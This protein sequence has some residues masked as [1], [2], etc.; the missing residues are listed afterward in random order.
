MY[1]DLAEGK[2]AIRN[3]AKPGI[4]FLT[5]PGDADNQRVAKIFELPHYRRVMENAIFIKIDV[6]E[7]RETL[8][9]YAL[10]K[11]PSI[12]LYDS[13]GRMRKKIQSVSD[14]GKLLAE[15]EKLQ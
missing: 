1:T 15:L 11:T 12:V 4:V 9:R 6:S 7:N 2:R 5:N 8:S 3:Q 13:K 14:M 10:Y